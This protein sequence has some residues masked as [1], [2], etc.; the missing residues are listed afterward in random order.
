VTHILRTTALEHSR[1]GDKERRGHSGT[2]GWPGASKTDRKLA[3]LSRQ[4]VGIPKPE[5]SCSW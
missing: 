2:H 1:E 4:L 3:E 5:R